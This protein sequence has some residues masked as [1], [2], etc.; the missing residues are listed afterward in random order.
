ML[1]T[2]MGRPATSIL[3]QDPDIAKF[4]SGILFQNKTFDFVFCSATGATTRHADAG[5]EHHKP[6]KRLQLAT[7]QLVFALQRLRNQGSLVLV[8]HKPES[9]NTAKVIRTFT[10]C[11][12]VRLFKLKTKHIN[13]SSFY[14]VAIEVATQS[15][16]MQSAVIK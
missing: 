12:T 14:I 9:F 5:A 15:K 6:H 3:T 16:E 2:K 7:S 1:A 10:K 13:K 4:S 8:M 11:S